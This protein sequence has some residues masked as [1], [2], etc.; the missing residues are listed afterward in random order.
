MIN[1]L[2]ALKINLCLMLVS[3][4]LDS[5]EAPKPVT[6]LSDI[7]SGY[8][9]EIDYLANQAQDLNMLN[10]DYTDQLRRLKLQSQKIQ[11][12]YSKRSIDG[13]LALLPSELHPAIRSSKPDFDT[14]VLDT[15]TPTR[16]W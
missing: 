6:L 5:S 9:V 8:L 2:T 12:A 11:T 13:L 14:P 3:N 16:P 10:E 4:N 15:R 7:I 1:R